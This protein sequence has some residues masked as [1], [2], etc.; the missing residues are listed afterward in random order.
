MASLTIPL[1]PGIGLCCYLCGCVLALLQYRFPLLSLH[2]RIWTDPPLLL[3]LHSGNC[4]HLD[5]VPS[6]PRPWSHTDS[7][8]Q[9]APTAARGKWRSQLTSC[10]NFCFSLETL[11]S[12][13][14]GLGLVLTII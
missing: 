2:L 7:G 6:S 9:G 1:P 5:N 12:D 3:W 8:R 11:T 13:S 4:S 14:S 10:P